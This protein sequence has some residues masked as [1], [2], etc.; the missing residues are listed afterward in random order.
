[1][2][3][4]EYVRLCEKLYEYDG[5]FGI[6]FCAKILQKSKDEETK[7]FGD[8]IYDILCGEY[9]PEGK[10][11][12]DGVMAFLITLWAQM[13]GGREYVDLEFLDDITK[14]EEETSEAIYNKMLQN[15][16]SLKDQPYASRD[17]NAEWLY[18][19]GNDLEKKSKDKWIHIP[20][21]K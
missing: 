18:I 2:M 1:M 7:G 4:R 20:S 8:D 14:E 12:D 17:Y 21:F 10:Y 3:Q 9:Y 5:L 15:I 13:N 16:H 19:P 6:E 11:K